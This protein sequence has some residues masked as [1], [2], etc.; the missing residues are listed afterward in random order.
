[1]EYN[2]CKELCNIRYVDFK[3]KIKK[4]KK[5]L[6]HHKNEPKLKLSLKKHSL[7]ISQK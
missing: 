1:M 2:I 4:V 7:K 6:V 5:K 3:K